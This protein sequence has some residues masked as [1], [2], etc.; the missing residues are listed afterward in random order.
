VYDDSVYRCSAGIGSTISAAAG[1]R[2]VFSLSSLFKRCVRVSCVRY[3]AFRNWV[4]CRPNAEGLVCI[5]CGDL[6]FIV[7]IDDVLH[8]RVRLLGSFDLEQA[9]LI[10][11]WSVPECYLDL[12]LLLS[13]IH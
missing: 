13:L 8:D 12:F 4:C 2:G 3:S 1:S 5:D 6:L 11:L 10:S 7:D 9:R